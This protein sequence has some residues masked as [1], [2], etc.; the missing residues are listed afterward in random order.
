[1]ICRSYLGLRASIRSV[2][3][4][5]EASLARV[6]D[7]YKP[8][9]MFYHATLD[10]AFQAL[11]RESPAIGKGETATERQLRNLNQELELEK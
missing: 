7:S 5:V 1:M 10:E 3:L 4:E 11:N 6:P 8:V 9:F 2:A